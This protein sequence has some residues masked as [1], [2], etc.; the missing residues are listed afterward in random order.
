MEIED[1]YVGKLVTKVSQPSWRGVIQDIRP[2]V[3]E[4]G[5]PLVMIRWV[6]SQKSSW[7]NPFGYYPREL[8]EV[9]ALEQLA[10]EAE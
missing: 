2:Q 5:D 7:L 9:S 1:C 8:S 6:A 4:D 10:Y 3:W